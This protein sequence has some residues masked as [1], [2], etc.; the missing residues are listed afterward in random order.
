MSSFIKRVDTATADLTDMF[1]ALM[2]LGA[3]FIVGVVAAAYYV[4]YF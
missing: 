1:K 4:V 3:G 2:L